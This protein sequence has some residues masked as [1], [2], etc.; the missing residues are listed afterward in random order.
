MCLTVQLDIYERNKSPV[1]INVQS[2]GFLVEESKE[3][4]ILYSIN[5]ISLKPEIL[6]YYDF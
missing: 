2:V 3:K 5:C 6:I 1:L 4:Y